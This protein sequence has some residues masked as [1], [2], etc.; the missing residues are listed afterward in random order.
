MSVV[1]PIQAI[2]A[3]GRAANPSPPGHGARSPATNLLTRLGGLWRDVLRFAYDL[4]VPFDDNIAD[5]DI[6]MGQ[7]PAEDLRLPTLLS[8]TTRRGRR[9][10]CARVSAG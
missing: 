8:A 3:V 6:R 4:R 10:R 9:C 1:F 2:I 7:T 5:Y